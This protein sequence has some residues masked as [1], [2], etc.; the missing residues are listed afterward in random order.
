MKYSA[1]LVACLFLVEAGRY[2]APLHAED[3]PDV[4]LTAEE[5]KILDM[6]NKERAAKD[7]P[8]LKLNST[9]VKTAR[10]HSEN[11]AKQGKME[12]N[13]D[14]KTPGQRVLAAGYDYESVRENIAAGENWPTSDVMKG[15][16][17]S[18]PHRENI[19]AKDIDE[20]GIGVV[21]D[22]KGKLFYTQDFGKQQK[23]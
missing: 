19:L 15:W 4:K 22:G 14:G 2:L 7:L 23:K 10:A 20:I 11:M 9:L 5:Q 21:S 1:H 3:K 17:E 16:M 6:T 8:P 18:K 12:H 13:L